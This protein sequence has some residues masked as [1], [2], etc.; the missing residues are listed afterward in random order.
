VVA[1]CVVRQPPHA[2]GDDERD[3]GSRD[4]RGQAEAL[5]AEILRGQPA[6]SALRMSVKVVDTDREDPGRVLTG[7]AV[8][9][10]FDILVL[11]RHGEGGRSKK[12]GRVADMAAGACGVP[13][14]LLSA[15]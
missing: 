9:H 6:G 15:K 3:D 5:L 7:Y 13:V 4:L 12:L 14:L 2:D 1:L 8:E 10:G 11:G